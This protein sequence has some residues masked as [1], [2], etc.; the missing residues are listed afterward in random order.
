MDHLILF[1]KNP[2]LGEVKTRLAE[3]V[4]DEEALIVYVKLLKHTREVAL[5]CAA[6]R[7]VFYSKHVV[8]SDQW[9]GEHFEKAVQRGADLGERMNRA[10]HEQFDKGASKMILI[11]S[12]CYELE[13]G[14]IHAAFKAL[15]K[16]D[17]VVG[18]AEDGGYYLIGMKQP[19]PFVFEDISWSTSEV[20]DE[21][22]RAV[23]S[24][25]FTLDVLETLPDIDTHEDL[26]N[27]PELM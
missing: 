2:I 17:F 4:G 18:P 24:R 27:Y 23:L 10:F 19:A 21:T 26:L 3:T 13:P 25:G 1:V 8:Q 22:R 14:H 20:F 9:S 5:K 7:T 12:D 11:G 6:E 15:D 16:S